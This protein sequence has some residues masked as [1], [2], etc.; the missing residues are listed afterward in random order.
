[1]EPVLT[2]DEYRR[3][4][5]AYEGDLDVAMDRAGHAV[6]LAA[7]RAG[8]GYGRR[9]AVLAGSGNNGG[10]GYVAAFYLAG[11]GSQVTVHAL[12]DPKTDEAARAADRAGTAGVVIRPLGEPSG[13]HLVIDALFGGGARAGMPESISPWLESGA[14]VIA[15]DYPSG[16]D[17]NTGKV[18]DRAFRAE[19]TVTFGS[20]KTGHLLGRGPD[21]CGKVTVADIG[22]SGGTPSMYLMTEDDAVR[23]PRSR[24]T[25]KWDVGS[26]L[27]VG[28]SS[29]L[30][31]AAVLA[32]KGALSY[33]AGAVAIATPDRGAVVSN[34]VEF[35]TFPLDGA[36]P[37]LD[38][39]DVIV[40]GPGLGDDDY[41][42]ALP[43]LE[44][45]KRAVIDAGG[46]RPEVA[47][48]LAGSGPE[49]VLTPHSRE[50]SR[51]AGVAGG[52]YAVRALAERL[53]AVVL[54]KGNP[55]RIS[56]GGLP[57]IVNA[58]GPELAT[59]GTGDVL[60][61]MIAALWARGAGPLEAATTAAYYHGVAGAELSSAGPLTATDLARHVGRYAW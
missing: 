16:L 20:L 51:I 33:G 22:I 44:K 61:G 35:P 4:D 8:A 25:H 47:D 28:G 58:G 53:G 6:A 26:V 54:L 1:M 12:A 45:S 17:P 3:V 37:D 5:T 14:P 52:T 42:L 59:I 48:L 21:H 29:G 46:L 19:E 43:F 7:V 38:R 31:G 50:F 11:R 55:T 30:T 27:V 24:T 2:A 60:S 36:L 9:V 49:T 39:F 56:D 23:P 10:D 18:P 15:V 13:E 40:F 41:A 57:V 32:A 34:T